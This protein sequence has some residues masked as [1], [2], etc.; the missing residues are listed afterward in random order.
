MASTKKLVGWWPAGVKTSTHRRIHG[1]DFGVLAYSIVEWAPLAVA[2]YMLDHVL[3]AMAIAQKPI[4]KKLQ[5]LQIWPLRRAFL[6]P[7]II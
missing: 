7:L 1:F 6:L 4:F 5:T 3:F 2:L